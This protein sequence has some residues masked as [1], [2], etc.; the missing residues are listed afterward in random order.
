M[1]NTVIQGLLSLYYKENHQLRFGQWFYNNYIGKGEHASMFNGPPKESI[2]LI[3]KWLEDHQ[4]YDTLP[5]R[6]K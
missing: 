6:L 1:K 5:K 2:P 3:E 4:Y